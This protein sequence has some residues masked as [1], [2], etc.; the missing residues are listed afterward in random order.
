MSMVDL[1]FER[2]RTERAIGE[3]N[4]VSFGGGLEEAGTAI[5]PLLV[6]FVSYSRKSDDP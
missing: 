2:T 1:I 5:W 4:Y 6:P 3:T